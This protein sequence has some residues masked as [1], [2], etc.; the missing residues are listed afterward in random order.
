MTQN[1]GSQ[2]VPEKFTKEFCDIKTVF[3]AILRF[4]SLWFHHEGTTE[5]FT[6]R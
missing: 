2:R 6:G 5:G 4:F 3:I 1:N